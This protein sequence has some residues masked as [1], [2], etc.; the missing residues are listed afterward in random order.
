MKRFLCG[1]LILLAP[2]AWAQQDNSSHNNLTF[3][4]GTPSAT[5]IIDKAGS[6]VKITVNPSPSFVLLSDQI[7]SCRRVVDGAIGP[8]QYYLNRFPA[9]TTNVE[10][11]PGIVTAYEALLELQ[12]E[13]LEIPNPVV[14]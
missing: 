12:T 13:L 1:W 3:Q 14:P 2:L 5:Q 11:R 9:S 4:V 7:A 10:W 8:L 6:V